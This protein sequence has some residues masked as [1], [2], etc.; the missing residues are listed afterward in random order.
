MKKFWML[1]LVL[2]FT[3]LFAEHI[4]T[5]T[6]TGMVRR[7]LELYYAGDT[8][9]IMYVDSTDSIL[10]PT[11]L[12][13]DKTT[14]KILNLTSDTATRSKKPIASAATA[15]DSNML[16]FHLA[17]STYRWL[18]R[19][20]LRSVVD[21]VRWADSANV[22]KKA[23][24]TVH[25]V[26]AGTLP[27][28]ATDSTFTNSHVSENG[29]TTKVSYV[30]AVGDTFVNTGTTAASTIYSG[31][32]A[33]NGDCYFFVGYESPRFSIQVGGTG[34]LSTVTPMTYGTSMPAMTAD[35]SGNVYGFR[36]A[37]GAGA[38]V[39]RRTGGVGNFDTI[40]GTRK[41]WR[42]ASCD[43]NG[44]LYAS[45]YGDTIYTS[46]DQGVT[47]AFFQKIIDSE[48]FSNV[49]PDGT[50]YLIGGDDFSPDIYRK[51]PE[52]TQFYAMGLWTVSWWGAIGVDTSGVI[53]L[54]SS[55]ADGV[56]RSSDG[57]TTIGKIQNTTFSTLMP[58]INGT[59]YGCRINQIWVKSSESIKTVFAVHG[60]NA[61]LSGKTTIENTPTATNP[62]WLLGKHAAP[63]NEVKK[64]P[65]S[66]VT[67]TA[68]PSDNKLLQSTTAGRIDTTKIKFR[69]G[70]NTT[71]FPGDII[72]GDSTDYNPTAHYIRSA[73]TNT[74]QAKDS[75]LTIIAG[76]GSNGKDR[77]GTVYIGGNENPSLP[78]GI[79]FSPGDTAGIL[80]L[81]EFTQFSKTGHAD[82]PGVW[83]IDDSRAGIKQMRIHCNTDLHIQHNLDNYIDINSDYVYAGPVFQF[84]YARGGALRA[85][86]FGSGDTAVMDSSGLQLYGGAV[87][88][89]DLN[90]DPTASG[91]PVAT[92]PDPVMIDSVSYVEFTSANN[93][94]CGDTKELPHS[95]VLGDSLYPHAHIFL[96]S[97]ESEG[98][99]GVTFTVCWQ[100]RTEGA[101]TRGQF[102]MSA[103]SAELAADGN[104]V[105]ISG[106]AFYRGT[107]LGGQL[108]V[109]LYRTAGDAEDVIVTT[110]GVHYPVD[111]L[112]SNAITTK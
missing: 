1:L 79:T 25:G 86:S 112:G 15:A 44:V 101:T 30:G 38:W 24:L 92:R 62:A 70:Y 13:Y 83:I 87:D 20:Q 110:Y 53:Y 71:E 54:S 11:A 27:K 14:G 57:L 74:D 85:G 63:D 45:T 41:Q 23:L 31:T 98:T 49:A 93:Q 33:P 26:T 46:S 68:P 77:G 103:T 19:A 8:S 36:Y 111:R 35:P 105:F 95:S 81:S 10:K 37:S 2:S 21:S 64:I 66:T 52:Q 99:T 91:G 96:K 50:L 90:F 80:N 97:G 48:F 88:W 42:A 76:G 56:Y 102:T 6:D 60:G 107:A 34:A 61:L 3:L 4:G 108:A 78:G 28:A 22:A 67:D 89:E 17:D 94:H 16:A 75:S 7:Q 84:S 18:T 43:K 47:W 65:L 73:G 5:K 40:T 39:Y 58:K 69:P 9:R 59:V 12:K 82:S 100:L 109:H 106:P 55:T 104:E 29:D 51:T 32:V 72:Q